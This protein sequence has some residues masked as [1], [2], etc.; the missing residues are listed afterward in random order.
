MSPNGAS[1]CI[2]LS[3]SLP[4]GS[5]PLSLVRSKSLRELHLGGTRLTAWPG[6][7]VL[8][9]YSGNVEEGLLAMSLCP[10]MSASSILPPSCP[11]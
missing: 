11:H 2:E 6:N 1:H 8:L 3:A 10:Q 4:I 5:V 9:P 7:A